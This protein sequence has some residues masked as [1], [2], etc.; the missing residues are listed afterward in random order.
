MLGVNQTENMSQ[1]IL[2]KKNKKKRKIENHSYHLNIFFNCDII[3]RVKSA[4]IFKMRHLLSVQVSVHQYFFKLKNSSSA[5]QG[6]SFLPHS[7]PKVASLF[8][9]SR[10]KT[11]SLPKTINLPFFTKKGHSSSAKGE[12]CNHGCD[13][14]CFTQKGLGSSL[15][16][17][18]QSAPSQRGTG[19]CST[20]G[21]PEGQ[22]WKLVL[23]WE[24]Q[25]VH[26]SSLSV[27]R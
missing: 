27:S 2:Q 8:Y 7:H 10:S 5:V 1:P 17:A 14:L 19:S 12:C 20:D 24:D 15:L 21:L 4:T 13:D 25:L 23:P 16:S 11:G 22:V 9:T 26:I 18:F 6:T 3:E